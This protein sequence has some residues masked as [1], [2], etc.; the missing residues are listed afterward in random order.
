MT[1]LA[2]D[3]VLLVWVL[4]N[5][6]MWLVLGSGLRNQRDRYEMVAA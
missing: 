6:F 4:P 3:L 5:G 1:H 2:L